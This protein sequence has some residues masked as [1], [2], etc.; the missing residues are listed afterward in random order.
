LYGAV[1]F[2]SQLSNE[3]QF[4]AV[5]A[6]I[7]G[8]F[9]PTA[10]ALKIAGPGGAL[11]A[12]MVGGITAI[13]VMEC[14]SEF[15]QLFPAPNAIVDIIAAFLCEDWAWV[16]GIAYWCLHSDFLVLLSIKLTSQIRYTYTSIF[17]N[18]L[19]EAATLTNYWQLAAIWQTLGLY[20]L[21]PLVIIALN[22]C[23]VKV[24]HLR[25]SMAAHKALTS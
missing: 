3:R 17:A 6:V 8:V 4:I 20:V 14:V 10:Q 22:L 23:G 1:L 5:S 13:S 18:Q 25:R 24:S 19:V 11:V 9:A 16:A 21:A 12:I 15:T 2:V 7:G